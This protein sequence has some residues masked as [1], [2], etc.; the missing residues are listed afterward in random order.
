MRTA[1][2]QQVN[3]AFE[4]DQHQSTNVFPD[5]LL[6]SSFTVVLQATF[7]LHAISSA[8]AKRRPWLVHTC[9][10]SKTL[11]SADRYLPGFR[12]LCLMREWVNINR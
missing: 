7:E 4:S 3:L 9:L 5:C 1:A 10:L 6:A 12:L 11:R 8:F 2:L